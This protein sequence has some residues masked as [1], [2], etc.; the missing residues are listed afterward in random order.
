MDFTAGDMASNFSGDCRRKSGRPAT[1][2]AALAQLEPRR[3]GDIR[4]FIVRVAKRSRLPP[5]VIEPFVENNHRLKQQFREDLEALE[6]EVKEARKVA[7]AS[8]PEG[9]DEEEE[10]AS[11]L[12]SLHSNV[13]ALLTK[14]QGALPAEQEAASEPMEADDVPVLPRCATQCVA[15][16]ATAP[17][18]PL[19]ATP[20]PAPRWPQF[21][22]GASAQ[23][24][25]AA[26]RRRDSR[27]SE[28]DSEAPE[29][30][31]RCPGR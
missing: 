27:D 18:P 17:C 1:S 10:H 29:P 9:V 25:A 30:R 22:C 13:A 26:R 2:R 5:E 31:P 14:W 11:L 19:T 8:M 12:E 21:R 7:A 24:P 3:D 16:P 4:N 6:Q 15:M 23:E 20:C 28:E